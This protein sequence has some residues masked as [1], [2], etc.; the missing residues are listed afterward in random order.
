MRRALVLPPIALQ[1]ITQALNAM[2]DAETGAAD[3]LLNLVYEE[4]R[5]VAAG[6]VA[7]ERPGATLQATALVHETWLRLGGDQQPK[8]QNRAHFFGAAAEAMRRILIDRARHRN[9]QRRGEGHVPLN[10]DDFD[11]A[12]PLDDD[13]LL[14]VNDALEK[15]AMA[16]PRKAELVKLR[17]FAGLTIEDTARTLGISEAT[18]KRWWTFAR[19]WLLRELEPP[20][21]PST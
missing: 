4:L 17:Y 9:T 10:V 5:R 14:A 8:W 3:R 2:H 11:V 15:F 18:A 20:A 21:K 19:A 1:E 12:M 6:K 16:D 7:M 13:G